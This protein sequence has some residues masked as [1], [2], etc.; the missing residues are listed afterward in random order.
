MSLENQVAQ[1]QVK[2]V[3]DKELNFRRQQEMYE[4]MLAEKEARIAELASRVSSRNGQDDDEDNDDDPYVDRKKLGKAL[5]K[6]EGKVKEA[7]K[8]EI[9]QAVA[10][11]LAEERRQNWLESN[12]DFYEIMN[13]AEKFA[14]KAPGIAKSILAMPESF[15]RQKLVYETIKTMGIHKP[16][17]PKQSIQAQIEARQRGPYYQPTGMATPPYGIP[18]TGGKNYSQSEMKDAYSKLQELKNRLRI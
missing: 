13:H 9:Q 11:A 5:N 4:K 6:F 14:E 7:T 18:G 8:A 17:E 2:P 1:E 16:E 10:Q 12:P 3:S 15:E